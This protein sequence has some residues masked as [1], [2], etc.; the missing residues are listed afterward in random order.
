[1]HTIRNIFRNH[2]QN[3]SGETTTFWN[4]CE[5]YINPTVVWETLQ[6][7][8]KVYLPFGISLSGVKTGLKHVFDSSFFQK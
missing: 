8:S 1:M 2:D 6:N 7:S 3:F 5:L 4:S